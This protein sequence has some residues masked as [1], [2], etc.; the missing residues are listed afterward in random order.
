[1]AKIEKQQLRWERK[2]EIQRQARERQRG[3]STPPIA[4][5]LQREERE[6]REQERQ[7]RRKE[8]QE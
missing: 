2:Q 8:E 6:I 5:T 3:L 7:E 1:M 4:K